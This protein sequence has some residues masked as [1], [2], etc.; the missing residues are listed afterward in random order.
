MALR[1]EWR[2]DGRFDAI[3]IV[4]DRDGTVREALMA[5]PAKLSSLLTSM[6]DLGTWHGEHPV[7]DAR[8]DPKTWGALVLARA[9]SGEVITMD[10][11]RY[12][13]GIYSWFRSRGVDYD[14]VRSGVSFD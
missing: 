5:D 11:E 13:N 14:T 9:G 7:E 2:T 8:R 3:L 6:G 12:W 1:A 10:P 4:D